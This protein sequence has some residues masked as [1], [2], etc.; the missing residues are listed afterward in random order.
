MQL[1]CSHSTAESDAVW[2]EARP[3]LNLYA[4]QLSTMTGWLHRRTVGCLMETGCTSASAW[5]EMVHYAS[6]AP[7]E[8]GTRHGNSWVSHRWSRELAGRSSVSQA[9]L[10]RSSVEEDVSMDHVCWWDGRRDTG[11][12][13]M[14]WWTGTWGFLWKLWMKFAESMSD[15]S[16][17]EQEATGVGLGVWLIASL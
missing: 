3:R 10:Q 16:E 12:L 17:I 15:G 14:S 1:W 8:V 6:L 11:W 4:R 9:A 7:G 2:R 5:A 13:K